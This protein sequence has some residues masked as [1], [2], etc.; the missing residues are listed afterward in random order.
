MEVYER[1]KADEQGAGMGELTEEFQPI[2]LD[3]RSLPGRED[4]VRG[5]ATCRRY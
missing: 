2:L 3:L 5:G 1:D 4:S